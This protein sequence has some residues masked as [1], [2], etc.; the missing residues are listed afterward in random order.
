MVDSCIGGK[1]S[2]NVGDMKNLVGNF[3]PPG[4]V[5][6]DAGF[7]ATLDPQDIVGGL[8]EA[9][10]ICYARSEADFEGFVSDR[11][12]PP[13]AVEQ[14]EAII[15]RSLNVKKWFIEI[16]EFDQK[17]RLLLNF[18]HT[19]G[20]A[21]ES[22]T[23]YDVKHGVGVGIGML[24]AIEFQK[25]WGKLND[26]GCRRADALER[27]I[28]S[29]LQYVP[30]LAKAAAVDANVL[31]TKFEHDKKHRAEE[32]RVILPVEDGSLSIVPLPK[33]QQIRSI[34]V[35]AYAATIESLGR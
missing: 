16:D 22:A 7:L 25:R 27:Y 23:H 17:E 1:S 11:P 29:I 32:Y 24:V 28:R 34:I 9:V 6:V 3:Y 2:I 18:G 5:L 33:N 12:Q 19:F 8:C 35:E 10:K 31:V 20:H 21:L 4:C 14:A 13:L 26:A 30:G 15:T